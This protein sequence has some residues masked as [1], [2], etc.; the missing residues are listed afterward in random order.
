MKI[1]Y[2]KIVYF[3][4]RVNRLRVKKLKKRISYTSNDFFDKE[5]R[6]DSDLLL[7]YS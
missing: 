4:T 3:L 6:S 1:T 2:T 7:N 5:K